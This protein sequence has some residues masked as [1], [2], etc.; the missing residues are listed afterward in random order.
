MPA[1][2]SERQQ[3]LKNRTD[4]CTAEDVGLESGDRETEQLCRLEM[5]GSSL[6]V[7]NSSRP[8][9]SFIASDILRAG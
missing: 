6:D 3:S 1:A 4:R 5:R 2:L 7:V 9:Q 8:G